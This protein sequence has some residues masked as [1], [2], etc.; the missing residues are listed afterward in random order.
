MRAYV[1]NRHIGWARAYVLARVVVT[2]TPQKTPMA[3]MMGSRQ[4]GPRRLLA[5]SN[6][7]SF[8]P[9]PRW[10]KTYHGG[11]LRGGHGKCV[12]FMD[13]MAWPPGGVVGYKS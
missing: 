10:T 4:M 8:A 3:S 2:T 13:D 7:F 1:R 9:F 6:S 5:T 12:V 11:D